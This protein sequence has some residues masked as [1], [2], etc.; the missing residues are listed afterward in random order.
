M[1]IVSEPTDQSYP[2]KVTFTFEWEVPKSLELEIPGYATTV[3][4][5]KPDRVEVDG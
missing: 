2:P 4:M 3:L 5:E 1:S